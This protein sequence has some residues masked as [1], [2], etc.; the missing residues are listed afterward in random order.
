MNLWR[1]DQRFATPRGLRDIY[2]HHPLPSAYMTTDMNRPASASSM[3]VRVG[4]SW[5]PLPGYRICGDVCVVVPFPEGTLLCLADGLGHGDAAHASAQVAC[6]HARAH[7]GEA[8]ETIVHG[9]DAALSGMRGAAVSLLAILPGAGRALFAG[10]GNV[11]LRAA[12]SERIAPPTTPGIVGRGVRKVRV[13]DYPV[14]AGDLL[15]LFSD[16]I[17][18]RFDLDEL[19]HL[20]PQALAEGVVARH[21]KAHDDACCMAAKMERQPAG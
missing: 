7:A 12:S 9:M 4:S 8:L 15:V 20:E 10:I 3:G 2:I 19:A 21:Q 14:A 13:W 18:S 16:G 11:E 6:D 5:R 17:S 1:P